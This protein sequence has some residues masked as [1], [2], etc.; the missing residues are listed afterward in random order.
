MKASQGS[1]HLRKSST[2]GQNSAY[3]KGLI[4]SMNFWYTSIA[5]SLPQ[6]ETKALMKASE[7]WITLDEF[8]VRNAPIDGAL[9]TLPL[10]VSILFLLGQHESGRAKNANLARQ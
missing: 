2:L 3:I 5:L 7:D 8:R 9:E 1:G 4:F 10:V 6:V